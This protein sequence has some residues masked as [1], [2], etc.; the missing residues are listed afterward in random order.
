MTANSTE[1]QA[2]L[3]QLETRLRQVED[4]QAITDLLTAYGPLVDAG[5][6]GE[7][8]DLWASD[9]VYDVE[10]LFM[11]GREDVHAMVTSEGHQG[12]IHHGSAHFNGPINVS[13]TGDVA[14]AVCH[15]LLILRNSQGRFFVARA[16]S[17]LFALTRTADGWKIQRRTTRLLDGQESARVLLRSGVTGVDLPA[18]H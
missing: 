8:A 4:V 11:D 17:H 16:G 7:V 14:R 18:G 3:E 13:V 6:A 10:G 15:S 1:L 12:L 2:R 9:G 5:A